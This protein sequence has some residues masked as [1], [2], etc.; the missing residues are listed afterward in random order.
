MINSIFEEK[1]TQQ[2]G[3]NMQMS[4]KPNTTE[5]NSRAFNIPII[6]I[7]RCGADNYFKQTRNILKRGKNHVVE[8]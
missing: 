3:R 5:G 6:C 4:E 1:H 7:N 8:K 2:K